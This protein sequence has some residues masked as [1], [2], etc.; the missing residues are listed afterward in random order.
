[1]KDLLAITTPVSDDSLGCAADYAL[2]LAGRVGAHLTI[3][4]AEIEPDFS[5]QVDESDNMQCGSKIVPSPS[6]KAS[7]F[8]D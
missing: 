2:E 4:I 3:L 8:R 6:K 1:M 5:A 7:V